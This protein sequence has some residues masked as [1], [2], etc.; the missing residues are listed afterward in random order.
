[1]KIRDEKTKQL[2]I[3]YLE[4]H[5]DERFMQ[6]VRNFIGVPFLVV[7]DTA[8]KEGDTFYWECDEMLEGAELCEVEPLIK[9]DKVRQVIKVWAKVNEIAQ[10]LVTAVKAPE[11]GYLYWEL[12]GIAY[13]QT[14]TICFDGELPDTLED[15]GTY[16]IEEL[17]GSSSDEE[18]E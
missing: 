5:P 6:A 7:S 1:M 15:L 12:A 13:E 11:N 8:P 2:F 17:C 4:E 10:V 16:T 18:G 9:D 14:I 3:K